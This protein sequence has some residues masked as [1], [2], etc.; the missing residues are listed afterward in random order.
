MTGMATT[1]IIIVATC[2][3]SFQAF[4]NPRL[5]QRMMF[6]PPAIQRGQYDRFLSYG[7]IHA[8][9]MHLLFNMFTLFFF[10]RAM[11][12][13]YTGTLGMFGFA[14]FYVSAIVVSILPTWLKHRHDANYRSLGASGAVSAVLFAYILL[15][16]W[17]MLYIYFIPMPA[18]LFAVGYVGYSVYMERR[19]GGS[20]NHSAHLWG[21]LYGI[22]FTI[23]LRPAVVPYFWQQL[24]HPTG[25]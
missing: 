5:M 14:I 15:A 9:G 19:G 13:F 3:V 21:G 17:S 18:I 11:E 1:I 6:W 16:P 22:L 10:G 2:V 12:P 4:N 7:L 24:L 25:G 23:A 20:I 8:D